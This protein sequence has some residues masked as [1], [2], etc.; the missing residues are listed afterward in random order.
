MPLV[1]PKFQ[2]DLADILGANDPDCGVEAK[3][4]IVEFATELGLAIDLYIRSAT[5]TTPIVTVVATTGSAVAQVGAGTGS[6]IGVIT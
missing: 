1:L 5:I 2:K 4:K 3:A 6:G